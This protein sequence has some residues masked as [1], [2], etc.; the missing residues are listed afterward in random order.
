M[1][2]TDILSSFYHQLEPTFPAQTEQAV[3]A[4]SP[5]QF[6]GVAFRSTLSVRSMI[7]VSRIIENAV[8]NNPVVAE[9][10]VSFQYFS[11]FAAQLRVYRRVAEAARGLWLYGKPDA[12]VP[13]LPRLT[14]VNT[15]G[16]PLLNYWWVVAY[17]PGLSMSL[18]AEEIPGPGGDLK[19]R[20]YRGFYTFAQD[21]A[22]RI[23]QILHRAYPQQVNA[24]VAPGS[25]RD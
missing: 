15:D 6:G 5:D 21:A 13:P 20:Q 2:Q 7:Y 12:E 11:R 3:R 1:T 18:L 16:T 14:L 23:L 8:I 25:L 4:A 17:G 24:P 10:H 19:S 22:Y 9:M